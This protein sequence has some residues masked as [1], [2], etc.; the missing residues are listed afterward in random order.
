MKEILIWIYEIIAIPIYWLIVKPIK[1]W[2]EKKYIIILLVLLIPCLSHAL[3]TSLS[4]R[5]IFPNADNLSTADGLELKADYRGYLAWISYEESMLRYV[6]QECVDI[7]LWG[8]GLG[9]E[10]E[11]VKNLSVAIKGGYYFPV[12]NY[13]NTYQEAIYRQMYAYTYPVEGWQPGGDVSYIENTC[14][15]EINGNFGGSVEANWTIPI[16]DWLNLDL[17]AGW[18]YLNLKDRISANI[19]GLYEGAFHE[20][21]VNRDWSGGVIGVSVTFRF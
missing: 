9:Y 15:Y 17:L 2:L 5:A 8:A 10:I 18:R 6:G 21:I 7:S 1:E 16:T 13:R 14:D 11:V 12:K 20:F 19:S 4:Y 3:D